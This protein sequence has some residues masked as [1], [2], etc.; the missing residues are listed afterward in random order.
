MMSVFWDEFSQMK[1]NVKENMRDIES[2]KQDQDSVK[3]TQSK[4]LGRIEVL[5]KR[6][7][8]T[9]EVIT[10]LV[11]KLD[12]IEGQV[13]ILGKRDRLSNGSGCM[14]KRAKISQSRSVEELFKENKLQSA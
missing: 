13:K 6:R 7:N 14:S 3:E 4:I 11:R 1:A 12:L 8:S 2:I 5:E 10:D 9:Q